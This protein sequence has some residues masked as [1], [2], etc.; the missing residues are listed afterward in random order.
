MSPLKTHVVIGTHSG[1]FH[2]DDVFAAAALQNVYRNVEFV[3][4]RDPKKLAQCDVLIDV[5]GEHDPE[6][7]RY[8]HH[9]RDRAGARPNGVLYS[10]FGLIWRQFGEHL[11]GSAEVADIVDRRLVQA[12]DAID[13]GQKTFEHPVFE[14]LQHFGISNAIALLNPRYD[15]T[16]PAGQDPYDLGFHTALIFAEHI[17]LRQIDAVRAEVAGRDEVRQA[18]LAAGASELIILNRFLPWQDTVHRF[19]TE[20]AKY[21]IFPS[22]DG[23][24]MAQAIAV[25]PGSF[26]SRKAF[27][28]E[29]RGLRDDAFIAKSGVNDAIFCHPGGFILGAKSREGAMTL[30]SLSLTHGGFT[31]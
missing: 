26:T 1:P 9:Q 4:T 21:I 28:E 19:A 15:E 14:G 24:W 22:Q 6:R 3:R 25:A 2:A 30:A 31:P 16:G 11:C 5:G 12:V 18:C 20:R 8:D 13:N 7:G 10:A 29:W 23:T 27:P 17:L